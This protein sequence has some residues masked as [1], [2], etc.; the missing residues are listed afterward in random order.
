MNNLYGIT[1]IRVSIIEA[2]HD[3][4]TEVNAFLKAH[5]G[6]IIDIRTE[7]MLYGVTKYIIIYKE[8]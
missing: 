5:D 3:Q 8:E 7:E 4:I 6:N 1:D 2:P